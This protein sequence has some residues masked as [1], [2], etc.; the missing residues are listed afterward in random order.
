MY[1]YNPDPGPLC[2]NCFG[3]MLMCGEMAK[4]AAWEL[5]TSNVLDHSS[6]CVCS[7]SGL[8]WRGGAPLALLQLHC[9]LDCNLWAELVTTPPFRHLGASV[10]TCGLPAPLQRHTPNTSRSLAL[11]E[12][13]IPQSIIYGMLLLPFYQLAP[14]DQKNVHLPVNNSFNVKYLLFIVKVRHC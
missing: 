9:N 14:T 10:S 2:T 11:D 4:C 8:C 1:F 6:L 5:Q 13:S 3:Q 12:L 7:G